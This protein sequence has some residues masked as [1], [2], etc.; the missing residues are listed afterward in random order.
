MDSDGRSGID[1]PYFPFEKAA[2]R[3]RLQQDGLDYERTDRLG[4]AWSFTQHA[5]K[6]ILAAAWP[7][8]GPDKAL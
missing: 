2:V 6:K 4:T 3:E 1:A 8:R 7:V 5:Q